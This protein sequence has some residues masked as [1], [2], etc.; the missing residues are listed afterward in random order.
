MTRKIIDNQ[1]K[2]FI[3]NSIAGLVNAGESVIILMICTRTKGIETAGMFAIAFAIANLM[4]AIGKFGMRTFQVTDAADE[5]EDGTYFLSRCITVLLM[6]IT[7][8]VWE[9]I[10]VYRGIHTIYRAFVIFF[11]CLIYAV[12]AIEDFFAG[13]YQKKGRLDLGNKVFIVRWCCIFVLFFIGFRL[14]MNTLYVEVAAL[15]L[16]LAVEVVF[17]KVFNK[18]L[19]IHRITVTTVKLKQLFINCFALFLIAFLS[20]Y[21]T[22]A[23]K[24]S[25]DRYLDLE[26]QAKY[27]FIAMPV[28]VISLLNSFLYQPLLV[29]MSILWEEKKCLSLLRIIKKQTIYILIISII[30]LTVSYVAGIPVLEWIYHVSLDG[31]KM[32]LMIL[33]LGG[34]VLAVV[35]YEVIILTIMRCQKQIAYGYVT[36]SFLALTG[37]GICTK[38]YGIMGNVIYY[39]VI[40]CVLSIV[41]T[42]LIIVQLKPQVKIQIRGEG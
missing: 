20:L 2:D 36:I 9:C 17:L 4:M 11:L 35:G 19:K 32:P 30:V 3:W 31:Y 24:Y 7:S 1:K 8:L 6:I 39:D 27:G 14:E 37:F 33:M 13:L 38:Y 16:S 29:K 12:E 21:I 26:V 5:F 18:K 34:M 10:N 28:F 15:M 25:I 41:F 22:N 23:P 42:Y 40:M